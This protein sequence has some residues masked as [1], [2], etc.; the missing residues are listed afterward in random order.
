M[1]NI[2]KINPAITDNTECSIVKARASFSDLEVGVL[3]DHGVSL[4]FV[5]FLTL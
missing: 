4:C 3:F 5:S 2:S 1:K